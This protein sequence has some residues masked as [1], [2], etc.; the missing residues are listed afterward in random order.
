MSSSIAKTSVLRFKMLTKN[1]TKPSKGSPLSAGF[2]LYSAYDYV[3]P[4]KGKG[5]VA[6]DLQI[7]IPDNCY[8]RIAPRS[9]LAVKNFIDV[10]AGV[11]DSDYRG[12][13]Q[14]VLFNFNDTEFAVKKGDRVA[15]LICERIE[16]PEL[17][18]EESLD[19]TVRGAN[20]FGSTGIKA[21]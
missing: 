5:L 11:V 21:N 14:I 6:T 10:G 17:V 18:E 2:D 12:N 1:A 9:G 7:A 4:A 16:L 8:G 3:I 20:G 15:Q 13:V 19:D